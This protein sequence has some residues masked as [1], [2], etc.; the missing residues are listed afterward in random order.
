MRLSVGVSALLISCF[1]FTILAAPTRP[2]L[3]DIKVKSPPLLP[4]STIIERS[5]AT[6]DDSSRALSQPLNKRID[7]Y[8]HDCK[9]PDDPSIF[10]EGLSIRDDLL[11][12][13]E[14]EP[15]VTSLAVNAGEEGKEGGHLI[16]RNLDEDS[17]EQAL[18]SSA[19]KRPI[20]KHERKTLCLRGDCGHKR[21]ELADGQVASLAFSEDQL[22]KRDR[23]DQK[24]GEGQQGDFDGHSGPGDGH[25]RRS[26]AEIEVA[27]ALP[28]V[29]KRDPSPWSVDVEE[30]YLREFFALKQIYPKGHHPAGQGHHKWSNGVPAEGHH[31]GV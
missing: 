17:Q 16:K 3:E 30:K 7:D 25:R 2:Y 26:L 18:T 27:A 13:R 14:P 19:T 22:I 6:S 8:C 31:H 1:S 24:R 29:E 23:A 9:H 21:R 28:P 12:K 4:D 11:E 10:G 15:V 20:A 5:L